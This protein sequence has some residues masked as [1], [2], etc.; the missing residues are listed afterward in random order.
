MKIE[1]VAAE[2]PE[3]DLQ[4]ALSPRRG[5]AAYQVR[6][7]AWKLGLDAASVALGREVHAGA[8]PACSSTTIAAWRRSIRWS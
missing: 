8:L 5:L 7:L 1:K 6:K 2:T 4:G 3:T